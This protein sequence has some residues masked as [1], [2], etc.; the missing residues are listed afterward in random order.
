M[1]DFKKEMDRIHNTARDSSNSDSPDN[2]VSSDG[3][4][5]HKYSV[6][7]KRTRKRKIS[8]G[9]EHEDPNQKR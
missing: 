5:E 1:V 3:E 8:A 6:R 9:A 7:N 2:D 4:E